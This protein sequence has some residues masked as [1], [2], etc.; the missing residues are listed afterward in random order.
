[1]QSNRTKEM[2][3]MNKLPL[4][5]AAAAV[6][7]LAAPLQAGMKAPGAPLKLA[8][9]PNKVVM[10][11]HAAHAEFK[12]VQCHHEPD[13]NG[14]PQKCSNAGCHD[15]FDKKDKSAHSFYQ[16]AH[17]KTKADPNSCLDCHK[18]QA[19]AKNLDKDASKALTGCSKS[20]CHP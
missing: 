8:Y 15:V 20:K 10:Y 5:L 1:M 12:C 3:V 16:L 2:H 17:A 9:F 19:K 6:L 18:K 4:W 11:P 13:A 14:N 7:L